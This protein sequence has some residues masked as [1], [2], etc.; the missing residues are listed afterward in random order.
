MYSKT[1][2][3]TRTV[4]RSVMP[5]GIFQNN[6]RNHVA[7]VPAPIDHLFQQFIKVFQND[8]LD[9]FMAAAEEILVERHHVL[10]RLSFQK[11]EL[12]IEVF[13]FIEI[14]PVAQRLH[15]FED[16][17]RGAIQQA[18]LRRKINSSNELRRQQ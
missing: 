12:F 4:T 6:M 8:Y 10:V 7:D 13:H 2:A 5:L 11:L 17:V 18:D 1:N 14:H 15:H 3:T 9:W 16:D